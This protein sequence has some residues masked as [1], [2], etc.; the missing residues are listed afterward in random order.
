MK[1]SHIQKKKIK[2]ETRKRKEEENIEEKIKK[3]KE[4]IKINVEERNKKIIEVIKKLEEDVEDKN[5][6][7]IEEIKIIKEDVEKKTKKIKEEIEIIL[8]DIEEKTKKIKEEI[9][10]IDELKIKKEREKIILEKFRRHKILMEGPFFENYITNLTMFLRLIENNYNER[11]KDLDL[12]DNDDKILFEYF[13]LFIGNSD[14]SENVLTLSD[15]W[16][17]FLI[18][19]KDKELQDKIN[20]LKRDKKGTLTIDFDNKNKVIDIQIMSQKKKNYNKY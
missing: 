4:E 14:F 17:E 9:K 10:N 3:I 2:E 1:Q 11:F 20:I 19:L 16:N 15:M 5:K 7:I 13:L 18:P 8:L 6:K 12:N